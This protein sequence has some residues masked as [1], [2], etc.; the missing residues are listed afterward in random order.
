MFEPGGKRLHV[1]M[2]VCVYYICTHVCVYIVYIIYMHVCVC[3]YMCVCLK[4]G[5]RAKR[6]QRLNF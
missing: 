5:V 1:Y 2:C 4:E 3:V 6:L